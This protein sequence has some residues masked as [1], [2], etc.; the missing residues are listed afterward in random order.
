MTV[1]HRR[2]STAL[3]NLV[4]VALAAGLLGACAAPKPVEP[5][6]PVITARQAALQSLGFKP[7]TRGW[8]KSLSTDGGEVGGRVTFGFDSDKLTD[9][10]AK[11][12]AATAAVLLSVGVRELGIEGHTDNRGAATYN[13]A[14]SERRATAAAQ[15]FMTAGFK[16]SNIRRVG[17]GDARPIDDNATEAGRAQNRRVT[18]IVSAL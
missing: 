4:A 9:E 14:L 2:A 3:F 11:D 18:I 5:A 13:Q 16:E 10:G 17:Y 1:F 6:A 7:T 12:I 15:V 8:E